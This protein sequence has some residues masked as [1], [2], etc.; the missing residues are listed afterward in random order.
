MLSTLILY[1]VCSVTLFIQQKYVQAQ[2]YLA[3]NIQA[4]TLCSITYVYTHFIQHNIC[5]VTRFIQHNVCLGTFIQHNLC[6]GTPFCST[7]PII[8]NVQAHLQHKVRLVTS[9][10][11]IM[12][13]QAHLLMTYLEICTI[14][15]YPL[16]YLQTPNNLTR[17]IRVLTPIPVMC[18]SNLLHDTS[19]LNLAVRGISQFHQM[20]YVCYIKLR[21]FPLPSPSLFQIHY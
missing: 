13:V 12:H 16:L 17:T 3:N 10:S 20:C 5:S 18:V 19:Y 14:L 2:L 15:W 8:T 4:H 7:L 21:D 9:L 6:S 11:S 1:I